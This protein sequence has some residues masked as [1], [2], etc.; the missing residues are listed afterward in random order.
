MTNL[1]TILKFPKELVHDGEPNR[2]NESPTRPRQMCVE[3]CAADSPFSCL[4]G[5]AGPAA[6]LR[7]C[8]CLCAPLQ[9]WKV[10]TVDGLRLNGNYYQSHS[11]FLGFFFFAEFVLK[12]CFN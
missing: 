6:E 2:R 1:F 9:G 10:L 12:L 3:I 8:V 11:G 4:S 5:A 7:V